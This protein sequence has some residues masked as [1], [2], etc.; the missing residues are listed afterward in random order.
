MVTV[1]Y[2]GFWSRVDF[3]N[4]SLTGL[5]SQADKLW[6]ASYCLGKRFSQK[7]ANDAHIFSITFNSSVEVGGVTQE[8][9][10]PACLND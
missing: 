7:K 10:S 9:E 8:N 6:L 5:L 3:Q 4:K 2:Q 1:A